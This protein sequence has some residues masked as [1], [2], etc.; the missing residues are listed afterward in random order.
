VATI[1]E[2]KAAIDSLLGITATGRLLQ[3]NSNTP[4]RAFEAYVLALCASAVK[5][6]GGMATLTGI[7][8]GQNPAV[9]VFRGGPGSMASRHQDFCYVACVLRGK[10]FEIH[11]DV[12]Y[13]GQSGASHEIDVSLYDADRAADVRSTLASPRTN[14]N[15]LVAIECKFY[16]APPGVALARTF[17]G[18]LSDC[19]TNRFNAFVSNLGSR[20]LEMYLAGKSRPD[21][22]LDLTPLDSDAEERFVRSLEQTLKKWAGSR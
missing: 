11:V 14:H 13:I 6:L 12:E 10:R 22:Y 18:L 9:C 17:Q 16:E 4:E 1:D 20:D 19:S 7:R 8:T 5:N 3:L 2:I 15:L 21:P